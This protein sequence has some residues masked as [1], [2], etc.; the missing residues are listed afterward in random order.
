[1]KKLL[2]LMLAL[3]AWPSNLTAFIIRPSSGSNSFS[4]KL[5][6]YTSDRD[7]SFIP[8]PGSRKA[9]QGGD[10]AYIR[11]NI[12]RQLD[13]YM[14]IRKVG[15]VDVVNDLY[16]RDS[17]SEIF[18]YVGKLAKCGTVTLEQAVQRQ[19]NLIEE[20][21]AR[22]RPVELGRKF[23]SGSLEIWSAPGDTERHIEANVANIDM[24]K[25]SP[26]LVTEE[27]V[28]KIEVGLNLEVRGKEKFAYSLILLDDDNR[29][30]LMSSLTNRQF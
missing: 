22:L 21:A 30:T 14:A 17:G 5:Q 1:M 7:L 26:G 11:E 8:P 19:W 24:E 15:G 4:W 29:E 18:W 2:V 27:N 28:K 25:I 9:P 12:L 13:H 6:Q 16:V 20:H 10:T 23:G 3:S